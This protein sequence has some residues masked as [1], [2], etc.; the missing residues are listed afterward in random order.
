MIELS[1][2]QGA[3]LA[4]NGAQPVRVLDPVTQTEYVLVRAEVYERFKALLTGETVY[5]SAEM[6]DRVMAAD[7]ANDPHLADLQPRYG[8]RKA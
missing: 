4:R 7:D 6:L 3:A 5:T 1:P 8:G 2:D